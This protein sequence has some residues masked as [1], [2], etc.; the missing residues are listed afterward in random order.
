MMVRRYFLTVVSTGPCPDCN[1]T[2]RKRYPV[3]IKRMVGRWVMKERA[4]R[5][6]RGGKGK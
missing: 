2:G 6:C 4:C 1:G 3:K 5:M